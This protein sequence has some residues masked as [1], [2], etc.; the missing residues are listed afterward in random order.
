MHTGDN[1]FDSNKFKAILKKYEDDV[2]KGLPVLT[3]AEDLTDIADY[4]QYIGREQD[5]QFVID[6]AID[7]YPGVIQPL[8]YK[9]REALSK[10]DFDSAIKYLEDISIKTDVEY[11][12]LQAE[13][14]I[15]QNLLESAKNILGDKFKEIEPEEQDDFCLNAAEIFLSYKVFEEALEWIKR[16]HNIETDEVK[17][18]TAQILG[19]GSNYEEGVKLMNELIDND[20]YCVFY[21]KTLAQIQFEQKDYNAALTSIDYA[22]AIDPQSITTIQQRIDLLKLLH[23]YEQALKEC[24]ELLEQYPEDITIKTNILELLILTSRN[25]E[26]EQYSVQLLNALETNDPYVD[27]VTREAVIAL[28]QLGKVKEAITFIDNAIKKSPKDISLYEI[29]AHIYLIHHL[30]QEA[31]DTYDEVLYGKMEFDEDEIIEVVKDKCISLTANQYYLAAYQEL[32]PRI[33]FNETTYASLY[34]YHSL[35]CYHL[36]KKDECLLFLHMAISMNYINEVFDAYD[37]F[38]TED[39]RFNN[40]QLFDFLKERIIKNIK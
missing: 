10:A 5:A 40:E 36:N 16:C 33:V 28:S 27:L 38:F 2:S 9:I 11:I 13:I 19:L 14:Y 35:C 18:L 7:L 24:R 25:E 23:N 39:F 12:Y 3:D 20:P 21:W 4:Y 17:I 6:K 15:A 1:Y 37:P 32:Q 26:A 31:I 30:Q 34:A 29:K 8:G 22:L